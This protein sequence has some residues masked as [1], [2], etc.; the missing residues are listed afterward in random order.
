[1]LYKFSKVS[2]SFIQKKEKWTISLEGDREEIEV[3]GQRGKKVPSLKV[4]RQ[5]NMTTST[6][7]T[8]ADQD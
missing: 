5:N 7:E 2:T 1:M 4:W 6:G 3:Y 8:E